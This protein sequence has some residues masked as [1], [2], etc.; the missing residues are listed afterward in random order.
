MST[1]REM[2]MGQQELQK[3]TF[4]LC[5]SRGSWVKVKSRPF[6]E[7]NALHWSVRG[8][9]VDTI[10]STVHNTETQQFADHV[11]KDTTQP[12]AVLHYNHPM[13]EVDQMLPSNPLSK[14]AKERYFSTYWTRQHSTF[15]CCVK[16]K[17]EVTKKC[18]EPRMAQKKGRLLSILAM[19]RFT[20]R[21]L[22]SYLPPMRKKARTH[23]LATALSD[24]LLENGQE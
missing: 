3:R 17:V 11:G 16:K 13:G 8:K 14:E 2:S 5:F 6:R 1:G 9:R 12:A 24:T 15:W 23:I 21:H 19:Q 20:E 22:P 10:L 7:A 18:S 4:H